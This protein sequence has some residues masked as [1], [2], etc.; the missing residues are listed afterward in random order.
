VSQG[1]LTR[2][3][4][5]G[6]QEKSR[7]SSLR[8]IRQSDSK[9]LLLSPEKLSGSE[10]LASHGYIVAAVD[11]PY[12]DIA[13]RLSDG[14]VVKQA[15]EPAGGEELLRYQRERVR[16]RMD[17]V[18]FVLDQI[19]RIQRIVRISCLP[20]MNPPGKGFLIKCFM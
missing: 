8:V 16:V 12:D 13:V 4:L 20:V 17:D 6:S 11:H 10:G 15:K 18:R 2:N 14:R 1:L 5:P 9:A 19:M 7:L 3:R